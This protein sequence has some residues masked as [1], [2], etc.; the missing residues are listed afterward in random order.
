M[1][2]GTYDYGGLLPRFGVGHWV[3][4]YCKCRHCGEVGLGVLHIFGFHM[5][6][7]ADPGSSTLRSARGM[8]SAWT[9]C[10]LT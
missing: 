9:S 3:D 2:G 6:K 1:E 4:V 7:A 5:L 8:T 10:F